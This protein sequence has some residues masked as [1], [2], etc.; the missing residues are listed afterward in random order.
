ML[1]VCPSFLHLGWVYYVRFALFTLTVR[2]IRQKV[3]SFVPNYRSAFTLPQCTHVSTESQSLSGR[4]PGIYA[5][6][7]GA[8]GYRRLCCAPWLQLATIQP[9]VTTP[10]NWTCNASQYCMGD[11][12]GDELP[13][14]WLG[15]TDRN[16]AGICC[17]QLLGMSCMSD[18]DLRKHFAARKL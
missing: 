5:G 11:A 9:R 7:F 2:N 12:Y 18:A 16:Q 17:L 14:I 3:Q 1:F 10:W 15:K 6:C 8:F 13:W 4:V